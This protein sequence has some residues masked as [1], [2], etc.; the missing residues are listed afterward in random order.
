MDYIIEQLVNLL[1]TVTFVNFYDF[2]NDFIKLFAENLKGQP[3]IKLMNAVVERICKE[4]HLKE[5]GQQIKDKSNIV[6]DKCCVILRIMVDRHQ[7]F[8][9][10]DQ[11]EEALKP[12]L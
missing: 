5:S 8:E 10:K 9:Q 2:M 6:L 3:I 12:I 1:N 4:Q 11:M 7:Y